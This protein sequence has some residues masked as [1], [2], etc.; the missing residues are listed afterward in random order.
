MMKASGGA[1]LCEGLAGPVILLWGTSTPHPE[2]NPKSRLPRPPSSLAQA[3]AY[4]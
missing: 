4:L 1:L 2:Q 3:V